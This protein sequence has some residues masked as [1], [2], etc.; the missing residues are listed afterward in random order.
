MKK[1][2]TKKI[3]RQFNKAPFETKI[4]MRETLRDQMTVLQ[5]MLDEMNAI[6]E[7]EADDSIL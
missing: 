7:A 4:E 1:V 2:N 6:L 3:I 5:H